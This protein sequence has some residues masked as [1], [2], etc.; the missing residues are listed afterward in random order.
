M[1]T[2]M[3]IVIMIIVIIIIVIIIIVIIV[4]VT[5]IDW[6]GITY[7]DCVA[8]KYAASHSGT[9]AVDMVTRE[10]RTRMRALSDGLLSAQ[11]QLATLKHD[12][13]TERREAGRTR[14]VLPYTTR[15]D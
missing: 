2:M 13:E 9:V 11:Q 7:R 1:I 10:Y 3:I 12:R 5:I 8:G 15:I 6:C 4:I 14:Q